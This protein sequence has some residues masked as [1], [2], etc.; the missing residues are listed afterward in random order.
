MNNGSGNVDMNIILRSIVSDSNSYT[1]LT[2]KPADWDTNWMSYFSVTYNPIS[3]K[4][5]Y[6]DPTKYFKYINGY[7]IH[8]AAVDSW[9][10]VIWYQARYQSI[11]SERRPPFVPSEFYS[12]ILR[13]VQDGENIG[14][15]FAKINEA[16]EHL[17]ALE[18]TAVRESQLSDV[19]F[20]GSYSDLI[21]KPFISNTT[22]YWDTVHPTTVSEL[23]KVYVYTDFDK[24]ENNNDIPGFKYGDGAT[25][26]SALPFIA[27][28]VTQSQIASWDDKVGVRLN[29]EDHTILEFYK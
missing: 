5:E 29:S 1:V 14:E 16:I 12:G 3:T 19:A 4:P 21:G 20:S 18:D 11:P 28:T 13:F 27:G 25:Y 17:S 8:G 24:D 7:Y 2:T 10:S 23:D 6:F 22:A 9:E 15:S 26:V